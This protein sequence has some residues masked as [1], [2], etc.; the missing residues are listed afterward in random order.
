MGIKTKGRRKLVIANRSF[1]YYGDYWNLHIASVG[2]KITVVLQIQ[3]TPW[4]IYQP[5]GATPLEIIGS[6][7]PKLIKF[8][9]RR[10]NYSD[11]P[12]NIWIKYPKQVG[13]G[14]EFTPKIVRQ[15]ID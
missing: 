12:S 7:F 5:E 3:F 2:I 8:R 1:V 4:D 6:E 9:E 14:K 10:V 15:I 13:Q 11:R